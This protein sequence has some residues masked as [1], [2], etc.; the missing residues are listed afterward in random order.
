MKAFYKSPYGGPDVYP[1]AAGCN[2]CSKQI[3]HGDFLINCIICQEDYCRKCMD[4]LIAKAKAQAD[5]YKCS[6]GH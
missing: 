2:G 4:G 6:K 3:E 1:Y 5:N